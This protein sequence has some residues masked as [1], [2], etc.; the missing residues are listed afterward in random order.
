MSDS[1]RGK[2]ISESYQKLVQ[3]NNGVF[4]DGLG[5]P[6]P[7]GSSGIGYQG[8]QG[9]AGLQGIRGE[10]GTQG[11][12]GPAA[13]GLS[14]GFQGFQGPRGESSTGFQGALGEN[15]FQGPQGESL[16]GFQGFQG[17]PGENGFQGP[18][19]SGGTSQISSSIIFEEGSSIISISESSGDGLNA[20][21]ISIKPD[22]LLD[23]DQYIIFD[24][25][26]PNHIHIRAGGLIY[27]SKAYLILGG[28][29]TKVVVSDNSQGIYI[30]AE[31]IIETN[32]YY[33]TSGNGFS[34]TSWSTDEFGNHWITINDPTQ[35]VYDATW[36]SYSPSILEV[37]YNGNYTVL[38]VNGTGTPG[39]PQPITILVSEAPPDNPAPLDEVIFIIRQFRTTQ[40]DVDS[41]IDV[42]ASDDLRFYA[43]DVF[44][45]RNY[46]RSEPIT[47]ITDYDNTEK[48]WSFNV[49]GTLTFP[50]GSTQSTAFVNLTGEI[51]PT[52]PQGEIGPTGP[53]GEIGPTGP[54]GFILSNVPSTSKGITGDSVGD[55]A[56]DDECFYACIQNYNTHTSTITIDS[57]GAWGGIAGGLSS[58]PFFSLER[59]P[60]IGWT[61]SGPQNNPPGFISLTITSVNP[62]DSNR[63]EIGFSNTEMNVSNGSSWIL[64]DNNPQEDI[65][66]RIKWLPESW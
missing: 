61:I 30:A 3:F 23:T 42:R 60:E 10:K 57:G 36:S 62:L 49:D 54:K 43:S 27:Q 58:I 6:L 52:G 31:R 50:D 45:L 65:W 8:P 28:E 53:Q 1:L 2:R 15:G 18:P 32:S 4:Y 24:P 12:Q 55:V 33:F 41:D 63:Y 44:S 16:I 38:S 59:V 66:R 51:G 25:T 40:I 21:T 48:Q 46:S 11:F 34:T 35:E 7:V 26:S 22:Y 37:A 29:K 19:G 14:N 64:T 17:A 13:A 5:N 9:R 20:S 47:I 56:F 39:P